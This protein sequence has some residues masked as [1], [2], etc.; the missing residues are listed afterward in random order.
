MV[1][2]SGIFTPGEKPDF[3]FM[4]QLKPAV[5]GKI[6]DNAGVW[7]TPAGKVTRKFETRSLDS[8]KRVY[9]NL[10]RQ[11]KYPPVYLKMLKNYLIKIG[12]RF[13]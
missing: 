10:E 5:A 3:V 8:R 2:K 12:R 1:V 11:K 6:S 7:E 4:D 13:Y 9:A